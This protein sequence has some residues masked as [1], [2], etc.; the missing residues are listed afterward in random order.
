[1]G[2]KLIAPATMI[3]LTAEERRT[4]EALANSA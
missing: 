3:A 1:M 4:L 2:M